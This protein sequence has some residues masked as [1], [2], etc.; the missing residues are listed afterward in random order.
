VRVVGKKN[1]VIPSLKH[2]IKWAGGE[3]QAQVVKCLSS[4]IILDIF[5]KYLCIFNLMHL[6]FLNAHISVVPISITFCFYS[7]EATTC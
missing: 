4:Q 2:K 7:T 6:N 1:P 5:K 3:A